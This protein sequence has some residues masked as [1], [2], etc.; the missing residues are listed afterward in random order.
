MK[1]EEIQF[2]S[3]ELYFTRE[4]VG[5]KNNTIREIDWEDKRFEALVKW[6]F[7]GYKNKYIRITSSNR[8]STFSRKITDISFFKNFVI[9]T[10]ENK[11]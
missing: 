9:I 2:K 6:Y 3:E 8:Q 11:K 5:L 10:W 7:N 1:P 4:S